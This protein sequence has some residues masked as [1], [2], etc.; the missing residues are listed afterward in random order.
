MLHD[1]ASASPL[2]LLCLLV[3]TSM[4]CSRSDSEATPDPAT[5]A[6]SP[7][8]ATPATETAP[9]APATEPGIGTRI[10]AGEGTPP[11]DHGR[12]ERGNALGHFVLPRPSA[13]LEDIRTRAAPPRI[14]GMLDEAALRTLARMTLGSR[15]GLADHL[16][17]DGPL[18][19]VLVDDAV[20]ELPIACTVA[21]EGGA[22]AVMADLGPEGR[23]DDAED[24]VAHYRFD[25]Q[26]LYLDDLEGQV[27][28]TTHPAIFAEAASDLRRLLGR[29]PSISDDVEFVLHPSASLARYSPQ[30]DALLSALRSAPGPQSNDPLAERFTEYSRASLGRSVSSYRELEQIRVGIG[31]DDRGL[32]LR[33]AVFPTPGSRTQSDAQAIASGPVDLD[34]VRR[35]PEASWLLLASAI[36]WRTVWGL[37]S[38]VPLRDVVLETYASAIER[39][40]SNVQAAVESFLDENAGLYD[41]DMVLALVHV[42]GTLGGLVLGR[43]LEAPAREHWMPWTERFTPEA[44]FGS[45]APQIFTWS[46]Q[47]DA[48]VVDGVAVDRW[49]LKAGPQ[50]KAALERSDDPGLEWIQRRIDP[51]TFDIDRVELDDRVL[52]IIAPDHQERYVR[53]AIEATASNGSGADPGLTAQLAH[54][55]D[56]SGLV[57]VDVAG[58]LAWA[59]EV[60]PAEQTGMLPPRLGRDLGDLYFSATYGASGQ[61]RG[62]LVLSQSMLDQLRALVK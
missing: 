31:L 15:S 12:L 55:P 62:E 4:S 44:V 47:A 43:T 6:S 19:C 42:P 14:A 56:P 10:A 21:Y 57:A 26:D 39:D 5:P 41:D 58:A 50:A 45:E 34:L 2:G 1:R 46:F 38:A 51:L 35:M 20:T 27:V 16:S 28:V 29:A 37:E 17:L 60:L 53:A 40:P 11:S 33:Y 18:G 48:M 3:G 49:T 32:A 59:R 30:V 36:D 8:P 24:H 52:F 54:D 61:Q 23:R 9:L 25:R 13:L 7:D 22:A